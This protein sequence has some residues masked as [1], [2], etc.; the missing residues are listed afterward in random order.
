MTARVAILCALCASAG[1][2]L[3]QTSE[4]VLV[5]DGDITPS[6]A[7]A[8]VT[9]L[10]SNAVAAVAVSAAANAASAAAGQVS[11][12]VSG[13]TSI[14][15]G[16]EGVG[17]VRGFLLNFGVTGLQ[18]DTN[19]TFSVVKFVPDVSNDNDFVYCDLYTYFSS[20][21]S[22]WPV[23]RLTQTLRDE[24]AW[25]EIESVSVV[26]TNV[27]VGAIEYEC[28]RNTVAAPIALTNAF[29]RI[30]ADAAQSE[31]GA[32]LPVSWGVKP[33]N[34]EP[35][36]G[37]WQVGTNVFKYQGGVRVRPE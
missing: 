34:Y 2:A 10:A 23:V 21:P 31:V 20:E 5:R 4:F 6:G 36:T 7:V 9:G 30:F 12:M 32:Y 16:L 17:Y 15:N 19:F 22:E 37:E 24:P 3:S 1:I 35:L 11:G 28:F 26:L 29:F 8:T 25:T 14:V 13:I 18:P 27:L 33:G